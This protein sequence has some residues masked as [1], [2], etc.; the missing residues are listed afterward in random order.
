MQTKIKPPAGR[1]CVDLIAP[2]ERF[3]SI[4]RRWLQTEYYTVSMAEVAPLLARV[5]DLL[6]DREGDSRN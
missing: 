4:M 6:H 1:R 2:D 3:L 5:H